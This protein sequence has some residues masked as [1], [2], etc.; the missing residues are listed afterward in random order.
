MRRT[1][2]VVMG[3]ILVLVGID[4]T[5]RIAVQSVLARQMQSAEKLQQ[6]PSVAVHG[7][8]FLWQVATGRYERV[9]TRLE[10]VPTGNGLPLDSVGIR[11]TGVHLP[12]NVLLGSRMTQVPVDAVQVSGTTTFAAL[13][14]QVNS[15][16]PDS[17]GT[18]RLRYGGANR[19]TAEAAY[20]GPGG[21]VKVSGK[22][23]L[24]ISWGQLVL[25][26]P[27]ESLTQVPKLFR[28]L[29]FR[30]STQPV[31]MQELPFGLTPTQVRVTPQGV[32]VTAA[33][34]NVML[35]LNPASDR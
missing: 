5:A 2:F 33:A 10:Q 16:I 30:L 20:S 8:P 3:L 21:P 6:R 11:L 1:F 19:L 26:L 17:L 22:A 9:E 23:M 31:R 18:V 7:F 24:S 34:D 28:P 12:L 25:T 35:P 14:T 13:Q 4:I 29:I 27:E 32:T 15:E